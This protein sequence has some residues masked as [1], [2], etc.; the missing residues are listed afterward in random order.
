MVPVPVLILWMEQDPFLACAMASESLAFCTRGKA[1]LFP[2]V[3]PWIQHEA[4][5][6]VAR[7]PIAHPSRTWPAPA[8][9]TAQLQA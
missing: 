1:I 3:S 8:P 7:E 5:E 6:R 4:P 2:G 9:W